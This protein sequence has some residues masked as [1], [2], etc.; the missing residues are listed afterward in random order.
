MTELLKGFAKVETS[1]PPCHPGE[2]EWVRVDAELTDDI[3][4]VFPYLNAIV[5][6]P[7]YDPQNKPSG[8]PWVGTG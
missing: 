8:S 7:V 5:K 2:V 3:R 1:L 6:G 4:P